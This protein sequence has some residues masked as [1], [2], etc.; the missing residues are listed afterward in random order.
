M[1]KAP[2]SLPQ[3]HFNIL[4]G[5]IKEDA[6]GLSSSSTAA[7]AATTTTTLQSVLLAMRDPVL[8]KDIIL[9]KLPSDEVDDTNQLV[10][11]EKR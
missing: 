2:V 6:A 5:G 4:Y 8:A 11:L 9:E 1:P 7:A 10:D 3:P